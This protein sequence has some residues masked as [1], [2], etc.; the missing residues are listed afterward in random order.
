MPIWVS[1]CNCA[2]ELSVKISAAKLMAVNTAVAG[3]KA[4][5]CGSLR[6][7]LGQANPIA[8]RPSGTLMP[9][10]QGQLA[11]D[12]ITD[13]TEGPSANEMPTTSAFIPTPAPS[14]EAG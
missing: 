11:S 14:R 10:S 2:V 4:C 6:G 9:K 13:A 8:N 12:R 3:S 1:D 5:R 7:R